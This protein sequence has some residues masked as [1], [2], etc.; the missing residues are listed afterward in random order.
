MASE[1]ITPRQVRAAYPI[2]AYVIAAY[3]TAA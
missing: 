1:S 3:A 2:A